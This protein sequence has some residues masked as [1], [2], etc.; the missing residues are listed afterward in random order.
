MVAVHQCPGLLPLLLLQIGV[1]PDLPSEFLG[2]SQGLGLGHGLLQRAE[3][4]CTPFPLFRDAVPCELALDLRPRTV[5]LLQN[6]D[7]LMGHGVGVDVSRLESDCVSAPLILPYVS[8]DQA[9]FQ[10]LHDDVDPAGILQSIIL[11]D[12]ETLFDDAV[13]VTCDH[14]RI[15]IALLHLHRHYAVRPPAGSGAPALLA[16]LALPAEQALPLR[17]LLPPA[18]LGPGLA[19]PPPASEHRL[20]LLAFLP[21]RPMTR[22]MDHPPFCSLIF[23]VAL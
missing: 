2:P 22:R 18:L 13:V 23:V 9:A 5:A 14:A 6:M 15:L 17:L 4:R 16:L 21:L 12:S 1:V 10:R 11:R 7:R 19:P 8:A 3:L 20:V